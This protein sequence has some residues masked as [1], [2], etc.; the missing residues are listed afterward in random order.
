MNESGLSP[1]AS[2]GIW[3][4]ETKGHDTLTSSPR[5]YVTQV[6][7]IFPY[8]AAMWLHRRYTEFWPLLQCSEGK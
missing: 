5:A 6:K 2:E 1:V 3:D 4:V 8:T 7:L